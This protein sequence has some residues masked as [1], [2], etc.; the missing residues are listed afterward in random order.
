MQLCATLLGSSLTTTTG[1]W[2]P[3]ARAA[4]A[5]AHGA[6]R[7][8]TRAAAEHGG[9]SEAAA[10][11]EAL[12]NAAVRD[13]ENKAAAAQSAASSGVSRALRMSSAVTAFWG[14]GA[15]AD[16]ASGQAL[17][18]HREALLEDAP[19]GAYT[20]AVAGLSNREVEQVLMHGA[21]QEFR[22]KARAGIEKLA[23]ASAT[24]AAEH[25]AATERAAAANKASRLL[26][27]T[28]LRA[29]A[30]QDMV[31]V[32]GALA[33]REGSDGKTAANSG[34]AGTG[35][36]D[37]AA[38][39]AVARAAAHAVASLNAQAVSTEAQ[40]LLPTVLAGEFLADAAARSASTDN[41]VA[42]FSSKMRETPAEG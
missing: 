5:P 8:T 27:Q 13:A 20:R 4:K 36:L 6:A 2:T 25:V 12:I 11:A 42:A 15:N 28:R 10:K 21:V 40:A 18:T 32:L 33:F 9:A 41:L 1:S 17:S 31:A 22:S 30:E 37:D 3:V 14:A 16:V 19:P 38:S 39:Q 29:A 26:L 24:A 7:R 34:A 35:A 23:N